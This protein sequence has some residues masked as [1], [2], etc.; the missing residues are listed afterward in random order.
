[1]SATVDGG[2][3]DWLAPLTTAIMPSVD[4]TR[5]AAG[6]HVENA[7]RHH[8]LATAAQVRALQGLADLVAAG[9]R[10]PYTDYIHATRTGIIE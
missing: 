10:P 2:G 7:V 8:S 3:P 6:L 1:M 5:G 9:K 4:A